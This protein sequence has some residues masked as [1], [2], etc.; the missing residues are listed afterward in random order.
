ML[1]DEMMED[2]CIMDKVSTPDGEGGWDYTWKE[3]APIKA[4]VVKDTSLNARIAEKEG[5]NEIYTI[6]VY[7]GNKLNFNDVIKRLRDEAIFKVTS[8]IDDSETPN[9]A[10][11]Q[12]GQVSAKRWELE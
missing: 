3:G 7:K 8:N 2:C 5:V 1:I 4:A 12:I 10:S 6:T 11:F 9:M